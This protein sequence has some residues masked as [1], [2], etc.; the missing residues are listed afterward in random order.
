MNR[1]R[2]EDHFTCPTP[3]RAAFVIAAIVMQPDS[4]NML[5]HV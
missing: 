4:K 1:I 2:L 3:V 5:E